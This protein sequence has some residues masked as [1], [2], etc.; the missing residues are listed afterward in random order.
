M[1]DIPDTQPPDRSDVFD[2]Q[3]HDRSDVPQHHDSIDISTQPFSTP[4][5]TDQLD[6]NNDL[7]DSGNDLSHSGNDLGGSGDDLS[8]SD[9]NKDMAFEITNQ[10]VEVTAED[11]DTQL[12]R[13]G[14]LRMDMHIDNDK[15]QAIFILYFSLYTK[16]KHAKCPLYLFIRP[17]NLEFVKR[18]SSDCGISLHFCMTQ[19]PSLV[20]PKHSPL[21]VKTRSIGLLSSLKTFASV[22]D[23]TVS[24]NTF[25]F[26]F[27]RLDQLRSIPS[28]FS[29][30]CR[31]T[32]H[33]NRGSLE[34]LYH[35][36]GGKIVNPSDINVG[37]DLNTKNNTGIKET[38]EEPLPPYP[39]EESPAFGFSDRK[40]RCNS[41]P[42][43]TPTTDKRHR[44][45]DH[46]TCNA[47]LRIRVERLEKI[48]QELVSCTPCRYNTEEFEG[49]TQHIH[50]TVDDQVT[51]AY[52]QLEDKVLDNSEAILADKVAEAQE[53]LVDEIK[54]K[55][56]QDIMR[57]LRFASRN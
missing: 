3:P 16:G 15:R 14:K 23:L 17:E 22:R 51:D 56:L 19:P 49:I 31:L 44:V 47:D 34:S 20:V 45:S 10:S 26:T 52:V 42:L 1:S 38:V 55:V 43:R 5:L 50:D 12:P 25:G 6:H 57:G 28:I 35:G 54:Q 4:R 48:I 13:T 33:A 7:S 21:A 2:T 29:S 36:A 30:P 40:R 39:D 53:Q 46:D 11:P 24:F 27:E 9:D 8:D 18:V 37:P 32:T 41:E